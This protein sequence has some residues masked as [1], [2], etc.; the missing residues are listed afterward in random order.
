MSPLSGV[1]SHYIAPWASWHA[2]A[3]VLSWGLLIPAG[4]LAARY[5]KVLPGQPWPDQLDNKGWWNAHRSCQYLGMMLAAVGVALAWNRGTQATTVANWHHWLGWMVVS[6]GVVQLLSAW[7]RG[8]KGGPTSQTMRGDHYDMT[9]HRKTFEHVHKG[10]GWLALCVAI[11]T[12]VL[13][14]IA[15]DAPRW[16]VVALSLWWLALLTLGWYWQRRGRCID[17]YQAIWGPEPQHPGNQ[18]SPI[19]WG[20]HRPTPST[21]LNSHHANP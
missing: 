5:F 15:A 2:R 1:S 3:M 8:T 19:G 11:A 6:A 21:P 12:I 7:L 18:R 9:V 10:L 13:G 4:A 14:L 20:V 16:M 17:T